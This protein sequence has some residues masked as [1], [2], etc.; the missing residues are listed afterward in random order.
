MSLFG[1]KLFKRKLATLGV[2]VAA[3]FVLSALSVVVVQ[4]QTLANE[5]TSVKASTIA[6]SN[7]SA[8]SAPSQALKIS[9]ANEA[10]LPPIVRDTYTVTAPPPPAKPKAGTD[11]SLQNPKGDPLDTLPASAA[12]G[13]R[14]GKPAWSIPGAQCHR[15]DDGRIVALKQGPA[16]N[17]SQYTGTPV[18]QQMEYIAQYW[19]TTGPPNFGYIPNEDCANFTSQT[20]VAR[21]Y[22]MDGSWYNNGGINQASAAWISSSHLRSYL[23][24]KPGVQELSNAQRAQVKVGDIAQFAWYNDSANGNRDHTTVVTKITTDPDGHINIFVGEHTDPY[25]YRNVDYM[26]NTVHPG[27]E[28]FFLSLP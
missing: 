5:S 20:L 9:T 25:Q 10:S 2:A 15:M 3:I 26:I 1:E 18:E 8:K 21:G 16:F 4:P 11:T 13:N 19:N 22:T 23:L 28:V 14:A 27:A 24:T 12:C 17:L 6:E 7:V